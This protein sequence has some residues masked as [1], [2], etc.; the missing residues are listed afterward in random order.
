MVD[1]MGHQPRDSPLEDGDAALAVDVLMLD[2][3]NERAR[4]EAADIEEAETSLV[5]LVG[6]VAGVDDGLSR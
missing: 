6:L 3:D 1:L 4:D 2:V 5:L